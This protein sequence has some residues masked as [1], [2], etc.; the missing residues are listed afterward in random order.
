MKN[1][2]PDTLVHPWHEIV[3]SA[4]YTFCA[5]IIFPGKGLAEANAESYNREIR[6]CQEQAKYFG[7]HLCFCQVCGHDLT[8]NYVLR[9]A[10]GKCFVVGC[11]CVMKSGNDKLMTVVQYE[12]KKAENIRNAR[13]REEKW[14]R[15][16]E[17][18]DAKERE[19]NGGKTDHEL[20]IEREE[21]R[22]RELA[23]QKRLN[24]IKNQWLA[25]LLSS[26]NG[27]FCQSIAKQLYE[28]KGL[29]EFSDRCLFI[30]WDIYIKHSAKG[31]RGKA[32]EEAIAKAEEEWEERVK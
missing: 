9:N 12:K 10:E 26:Q 8:W 2:T 19:K 5:V 22:K 27:D 24:N 14:K 28:G 1:L 29:D 7:V 20:Y 21:I 25:Q 18:R 4:P 31:L 13:I 6:A 16:C 32:R 17:A 23:E 11:D 3:G 15:E 30:M